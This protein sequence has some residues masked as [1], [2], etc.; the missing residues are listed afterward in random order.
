[1]SAAEQ[2]VLR[3]DGLE[4]VMLPEL[5][6]RIHRLRVD[7]VD[8]LRTPED[9]GTHRDDPFF[10]GAYVM[11]PWC[12]RAPAEPFDVAGRTVRL[13][14][15]FG[16]GSA[17]HGL[18]YDRPWE[19]RDDGSLRVAIDEGEGGWPWAFEVTVHPEVH[20]RTLSLGYEVVNRS[21]APMPAGIGLHPWF[22][23]PVTLGVPAE[24]VYPV[25]TA[26]PPLP[27]PI[28]GTFDLRSAATP[29]PGVDATWTNLATP[30]VD[31]V[32][33]EL[34]L[35]ATIEVEAPRVCVAVA[36]PEPLGAVAVEPQTHAPDGLRRVAHGEPDAPD[37]LDPGASL[38]LALR[39]TF[40][41]PPNG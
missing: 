12:N 41:G 10:W 6:A 32:W 24:A 8:L 36:A 15:N 14:A 25:N 20:G 3:G 21:D 37:L 35:G 1:M 11:A 29:P 16:D 4:L 19:P 27:S 17:I 22:V 7:D 38:R 34:G 39:V 28:E 31:L 9:A 33:P 5:G 30:A 40:T 2:L 18:V 23:A 13:R 26:S